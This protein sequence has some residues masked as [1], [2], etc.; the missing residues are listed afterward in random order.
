VLRRAF[1]ESGFDVSHARPQYVLPMA[2]HRA[3]GAVSLSRSVENGLEALG[4]TAW[5][6]SPVLVRADRAR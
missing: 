1:H 4:L 2:L 6:G 5:L 3:L